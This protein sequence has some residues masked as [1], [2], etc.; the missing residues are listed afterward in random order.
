MIGNVTF[1]KMSVP[2]LMNIPVQVICPLDMCF[3]SFHLNFP[4]GYIF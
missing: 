4:L 3:L 1:K 2:V